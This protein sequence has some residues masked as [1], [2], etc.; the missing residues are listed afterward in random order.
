MKQSNL[1]RIYRIDKKV[2]YR[3]LKSKIS[4]IFI[5]KFNRW[6]D[7]NISTFSFDYI[8]YYKLRKFEFNIAELLGI[9]LQAEELR[10]FS[11]KC[12]EHRFKVLSSSEQVVNSNLSFSQIQSRYPK[13]LIPFT[14][15]CFNKIE[16]SYS[17]INWQKDFNSGF[18]WDFAWFKDIVYG[19]DSGAD[20]KVPWEIGRLQHLPYLA[21]QFIN[22]GEAKYRSELRNQ[23][24]D[25]MASNPTNFGTQWMTSMDIG[26]RLVNILIALSMF[27]NLLDLLDD[28]ELELVESY[29][30][31]HYLHIKNN[32]EFSEGMRGN[33]YLA[34]LCSLV[35]YLCLID[36][37][38]TNDA[39][40]SRY[41]E[42]IDTELDYQFYADGTNFEGSTRYHIFVSQML[43]T[44]DLILQKTKQI[45]LRKD[46]MN[47]IC[48]FTHRLLDY[49]PPPQIGDNDSGFYWKCLDDEGRTYSV[50][51]SI[52]SN[53]YE[54]AGSDKW[55]D[56]GYIETRCDKA[57]LIFKCGKLGQ[58]GKGGH[59]H[60]D[61][62]SYQIYVLGKP[63][64]I[65]A[66]TFAYTSDYTKRNYYRSTIAHNPVAIADNEQNELSGMT[67]DDMFWVDTDNSAPEILKHEGD[68]ISAKINYCG[69]PYT[70]T[71]GVNNTDIIVTD[72]IENNLDK[73]IHIYLH[74][75][76]RIE[77]VENDVYKLW[78]NENCIILETLGLETEVKDCYFSPEYGVEVATKVIIINS[79]DST[80]QHK[81]RV[82]F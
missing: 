36:E 64:V 44:A 7:Y 31:D 35:I 50:L 6:R 40:L 20:I 69:K 61:N 5:D 79:K 10:E 14:T 30:F 75:G 63:F 11:D 24:F 34:N 80:I 82:A 26:I 16:N 73:K 22:T 60:N 32:I 29:L 51:K 45:S 27:D 55:L 23:L 12:L 58:S 66:G 62:L 1:Q 65:D 33:H 17:L 67:N 25:F 37:A 70:R 56:F 77:Y 54:V 42:L 21:L 19:N 68:T 57:N 71:I 9:S 41:L 43:I 49:T 72:Y 15:N 47:K 18:E 39:I 28:R 8:A 59:N 52:I 48:S 76:I 46:K 4:H 2:I 38:E 74:S 78:K 3:K 13:K 53:N 81:F